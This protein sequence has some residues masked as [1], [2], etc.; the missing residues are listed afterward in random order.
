AAPGMGHVEGRLGAE[1]RGPRH[2]GARAA[3]HLTVADPPHVIAL[4]R[5]RRAA[6][7]V[8][9]GASAHAVHDDVVRD[10]EAGVGVYAALGAVGNDRRVAAVL[11]LLDDVAGDHGAATVGQ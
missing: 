8:D 5:R 2:H 1:V 3:R 6:G 7:V 9:E 10:E 11:A 4:N